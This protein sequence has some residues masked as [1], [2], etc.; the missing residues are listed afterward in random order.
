MG[1]LW[2]PFWG[3]FSFV[4]TYISRRILLAI[5]N[6]GIPRQPRYFLGVGFK[7]HFVFSPRFMG[8]HG[9]IWRPAYFSSMGCSTTNKQFSFLFGVVETQSVSPKDMVQSFLG[10]FFLTFV[11]FIFVSFGRLWQAMSSWL[12][13]LRPP[14]FQG[15]PKTW[16][17]F[18]CWDS[19]LSKNEIRY[20]GDE[21]SA[22]WLGI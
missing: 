9:P 5:W 2:S 16:Q 3:T 17:S 10:A 14:E 7:W 12:Q 11:A 21:E 8:F 13:E 4:T 19:Q 6:L 1:E 18:S 15:F 20:P 22:S